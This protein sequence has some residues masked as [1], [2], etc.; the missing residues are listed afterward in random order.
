MSTLITVLLACC[1]VGLLIGIFYRNIRARRWRRLILQCIVLSIVVLLLN[2]WFGFPRILETKGAGE[3]RIAEIIAVV[4]CYVCMVAGMVAQYFFSQG[5]QG[6]TKFTFEIVPFLMPI[7]ASPI[8]F[9]PLLTLLLRD[10][11]MTGA[12]EKS[13]LM[14]YFVAFQNGFF[15]K[16]M[17]ERQRGKGG[18]YGTSA[19]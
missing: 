7:F 5:Q 10:S 11:Q 3:E 4:L 6:R 12:L 2:I 13:K 14:V 17:F 8:I 16:D 9:I 15:W 18:S 1:L 19:D